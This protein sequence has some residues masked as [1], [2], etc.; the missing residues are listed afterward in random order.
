MD[1]NQH[2][3]SHTD[4]QY[5]TQQQHQLQLQRQQQLQAAQFH[6]QHRPQDVSAISRGQN[7]QWLEQQR[8]QP[9]GISPGHWPPT[10]QQPPT[11]QAAVNHSSSVWLK[12]S[13]ASWQQ[14]QQHR[15]A[16]GR[17][18]LSGT[19]GG[20]EVPGFV[21]QDVVSNDGLFSTVVTIPNE[22]CTLVIGR[23]E[24][25]LKSLQ[26]QSGT[27][28]AIL[29]QKGLLPHR[30]LSVRSASAVCVDFATRLIRDIVEGNRTVIGALKVKRPAGVQDAIDANKAA[31]PA[32]ATNIASE[33]TD[34]KPTSAAPKIS[35]STRGSPS[36]SDKGVSTSSR[37]T[38]DI[39]SSRD[40]GRPS[41]RRNDEE[42][43]SAD[44]RR[45]SVQQRSAVPITERLSRPPD[46]TQATR[47]NKTRRLSNTMPTPIKAGSS[48]VKSAL[49]NKSLTSPTKLLAAPNKS[50]VSPTKLSAPNKSL[51]SPTKSGMS[52]RTPS[53]SPSKT[54]VTHPTGPT[55]VSAGGAAKTHDA[56]PVTS[57]AARSSAA[58]PTATT[59]DDTGGDER[60][61]EHTLHTVSDNKAVEKLR[62]ASVAALEALQ[63]QLERTHQREIKLLTAAATVLGGDNEDLQNLLQVSL[64]EN[65]KKLTSAFLRVLADARATAQN[66]FALACAAL[67]P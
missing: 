11:A 1:P 24:R 33:T 20:K 61:E 12:Q 3:M 53:R 58:A 50:L 64:A 67:Q 40:G 49:P 59:R 56:P 26:D 6:T 27:H 35:S 19:G 31:P 4:P 57:A 62:L 41:H 39:R 37:S 21:V 14:D 23:Q 30:R 7:T 28:M 25:T 43:T 22:R 32:P 55:G 65:T 54:V 17:P 8:G 5:W 10:Q 38:R 36:T 2:W 66:E 42:S 29:P 46:T 16:Q 9:S 60:M 63:L 44:S 52:A 18:R 34:K 47:P 51:V 45:A 13:A 48:P 15:L